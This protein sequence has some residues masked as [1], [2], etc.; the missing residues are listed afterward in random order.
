ME[1]SQSSA[2]SNRVTTPLLLTPYRRPTP[3]KRM[4]YGPKRG[5]IKVKLL[6]IIKNP[7]EEPDEHEM[8]CLSLADTLRKIQDPQKKEHTKLQ[9]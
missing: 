9:L 6:Q 3:G 8:F 2:S 4:C 7:E 5:A 1:D